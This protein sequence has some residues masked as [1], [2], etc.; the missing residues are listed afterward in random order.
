MDNLI[1]L[2]PLYLEF[3]S[4]AQDLW[5]ARGFSFWLLWSCKDWASLGRWDIWKILKTRT[6]PTLECVYVLQKRGMQDAWPGL[7]FGISNN[8]QNYFTS[9]DPHPDISFW[10]F[11]WHSNSFWHST[12]HLF[13]HSSW[14]APQHPELAIWCS[15]PGALHCIRTSPH[16]SDPFMPT[17]LT[18]WQKQ[19]AEKVDE[20]EGGERGRGEEEEG[21]GEIPL[22]K[23][24]DPHLAGGEQK[25]KVAETRRTSAIR[26]AHSCHVVAM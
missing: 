22:L 1:T 17:V 10:H 19:E 24:R 7:G 8:C 15:G 20:D 4:K 26:S 9:S 13:W 21:R 23:T 3:L 18:S 12:S 11:I 25:K 2:C 5:P 6:E 14:H 16:G